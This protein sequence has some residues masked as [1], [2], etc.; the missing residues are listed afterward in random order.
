MCQTLLGTI[1]YMEMER[2]GCFVYLEFI[3]FFLFILLMKLIIFKEYNYFLF[4]IFSHLKNAFLF[5]VSLS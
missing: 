1:W 3:K 4:L 5:V 2:N